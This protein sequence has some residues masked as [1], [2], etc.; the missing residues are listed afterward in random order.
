[1]PR[2]STDFTISVLGGDRRSLEVAKV[3]LNMG[4]DVRVIG[5]DLGTNARGLRACR[6]A[7][8]AMAGARVVVAPI[9]G[10]ADDGRVFT[11]LNIPPLVLTEEDLSV[12][13]RGAYI[14]AGLAGRRVLE[15]AGRLALEV[16]ELR[17]RDDFAIYN[18]IPSAE[19]AIQMAM[20][21]LPITIHGCCAF[22]LG[23]GRTGITVAR[24]LVAMGADTT[25]VARNAA[26]RARATEMRCRAI[27][28]PR[29]P[30]LISEADVIFNTIPARVLDAAVLGRARRDLVVIDLAS[31]PGGT[32][33]AFAAEIGILAVLAPGLPGKVAPV[34]AAR[35]IADLILRT[36]EE[37]GEIP[38]G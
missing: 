32:D 34:T 21:R 37:K 15:T 27:D 6:T 23:F 3:F 4:A 7:R 26:D 13:P 24:L 22:V 10:I 31:D 16:V 18:S 28:F 19:G 8:E 14:F 36:L 1:M 33:F 12:L 35:I 20:E 30:A 38:P 11:G 17:N 5:L 9:Q 25:V 29:L 2:L